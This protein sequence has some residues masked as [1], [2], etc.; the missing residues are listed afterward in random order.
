LVTVDVPANNE[1]AKDEAKEAERKAKRAEAQRKRREA[2]K[3]GSKTSSSTSRK[4]TSDPTQL[5]ILVLTLTS[6]L[7]SKEGFEMWALSEAEVSQL[8][9]PLHSM[10]SKHEGVGEKLGQYA[11][12][13][14]LVTAAFT[15]LVPRLVMQIQ[16]NKQK[17]GGNNNAKH[18]HTNGGSSNTNAGT[19]ERDNRSIS[20]QPANNGTSFGNELSS[21]IPPVSF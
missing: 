6:I 11:D 7:A 3:G 14:A 12:H 15:I 8:V 1:A 16:M 21:L 9:T 18:R 20:K 10:L 13:I 2:A 19:T 5:K 4:Q 17:K